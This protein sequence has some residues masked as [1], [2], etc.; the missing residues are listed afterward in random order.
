MVYYTSSQ[1]IFKENKTL[2]LATV[3]VQNLGDDISNAACAMG[4]RSELNGG[5]N[6][7]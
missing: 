7:L 4:D 5:D 1:K 6:I 3:H 2:P